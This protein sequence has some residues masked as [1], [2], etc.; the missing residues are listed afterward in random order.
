MTPFGRSLEGAADQRKRMPAAK[1]NSNRPLM[2]A[3]KP[4]APTHG[5]IAAQVPAFAAI[6]LI[7]YVVDAAVT[8]VGAKYLGFSPELARPPGFIVA[9][10]VNFALNRSIT[11]RHARSPLAGSFVRYSLVASVG[12]A[13]NYA[14]YS[15]CVALAP[16]AGIA[17]TPAILPVFIAAGS[18]VAMAATFVGFRFFA[19]RP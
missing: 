10:I 14:V 15:A 18:G 17:V 6:G 7:G 16:I 13:I 4:A 19:F 9:T 2:N 11:F 8:F 1:F 3:V 5:R 12:L